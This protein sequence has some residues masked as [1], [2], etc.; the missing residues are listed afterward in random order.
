MRVVFDT[1]IFVSALMIPG[2]QAERALRRILD[3][4]DVLLVSRPIVAEL[5]DVLGRK[6]QRGV[7]ELARV[8]VFV[9]ELGEMVRPSR[10]VSALPDERDN[11]VLACAVAGHAEAIVTGDGAMLGL[12]SYEGIRVVTLRAYVSGG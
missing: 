9:G 8:A 2:G 4:R 11:E 3:R 6:F 1:N 12:G 10:R 5:V 7:E